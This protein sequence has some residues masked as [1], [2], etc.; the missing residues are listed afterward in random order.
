MASTLSDFQKPYRSL[1]YRVEID[2]TGTF[3]DYANQVQ[4]I[5]VYEKIENGVTGSISQ[6]CDIRLAITNFDSSWQK[7]GLNVKVYVSISSDNWASSYEYLW[8]EGITT[9]KTKVSDR[10]VDLKFVSVLETLKSNKSL[11]FGSPD[12]Q[13]FDSLISTFTYVNGLSQITKLDFPSNVTSFSVPFL[14]GIQ[15]LNQG[16]V[17]DEICLACNYTYRYSQDKYVFRSVSYVDRLASEGYKAVY[18]LDNIIKYT[19]RATNQT[20]YNIVTSE[21]RVARYVNFTDINNPLYCNLQLNSLEVKAGEKLYLL[22]DDKDLVDYQ[23]VNPIG[24]FNASYFEAYTTDD[25]SLPF[26]NTGVTASTFSIVLKDNKTKFLIIFNNSNGSSRYIKKI[27]I[28][29]SGAVQTDSIT[30][31]ATGSEVIGDK[32]NI[33][34]IITSD[35]IVTSSQAQ[36]IAN[37]ILDNFNSTKRYFDITIK[38]NPDNKV[39]DIIR[40]QLRDLNYVN[41]VIMEIDSE[42]SRDRGFEQSLLVK[43]V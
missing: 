17:L 25:F 26:D 36:L 2:K 24:G 30:Y 8:Y 27:C 11:G 12:P 14:V 1:R 7:V 37:E 15:G 35:Y 34:Y 29:G 43:E 18:T 6:D 20:T 33:E 31:T 32:Q 21:G 13:L 28:N 5:N 16:K 4:Y 39:G 23:S 42:I 22:V 41:V 9:N 3:E 38:G 40:I 19:D 10:Y